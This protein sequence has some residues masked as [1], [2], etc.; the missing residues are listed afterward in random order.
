MPARSWDDLRFVLAVARRRTL[1]AAAIDLGVTQPTVG[2]RVT[3]FERRLGSALFVRRPDGFDVTDAGRQLVAHAE[4]IERDVLEVEA[5]VVGRDAGLRGVVRVTASEWLCTSVL[6]RVVG[7]LL[8]RHPQLE[9]ELIADQRHLNLARR[10]ADVALRPRR[11]DHD[12]IVQRSVG[13][14]EL[15]LYASARYLAARGTPRAR[16]GSGHVVVGMLE[17]VGDLARDWL[18]LALPH[19]TTPIRTNGRDAMVTLAHEGVGLACLARVVGDRTVGLRR[20]VIEPE[21]PAPPLWLG[22]H[23]DARATPR[24]RA[25]A[26]YLAAAVA[27][28]LAAS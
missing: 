3:A 9:L 21:P 28:Q 12:A 23:R 1:S 18:A 24:V 6:S 7:E 10:E 5:R 20:V 16:D 19:A 14:L 2:R 15:G 13:K 22:V 4:R 25:V 17:G 11:F 27:E 26:S 8:A